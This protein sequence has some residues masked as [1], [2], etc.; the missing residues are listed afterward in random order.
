M[1]HRIGYSIFRPTISSRKELHRYVAAV[2]C[3]AL[4]LALTVDV[5]NQLT[6]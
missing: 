1:K 4:G 6:F 5:V 2:A 3:A